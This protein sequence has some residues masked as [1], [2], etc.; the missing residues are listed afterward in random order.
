MRRCVA[1][2]RAGGERL[3]FSGRPPNALWEVN[4]PDVLVA[5]GPIVV[6]IQS[7]LAPFEVVE[8]LG[9]AVHDRPYS[10]PGRF[11]RGFFRLGGSVAGDR[12]TL[13]ARP[14]VNPGLI[15]GFGAMTIELSGAV[16][17]VPGGSELAGSVSAPVR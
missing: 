2:Y 9:R 8:R 14:Y 10:T 7:G 17:P 13:T 11:S 6:S 1:D 12:I 3:A 16:T 5:P 4:V 15:A